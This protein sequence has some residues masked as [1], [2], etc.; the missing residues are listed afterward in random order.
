MGRRFAALAATA[1]LSMVVPGEAAAATYC[2]GTTGVAC[3]ETFAATGD[4]VQQALTAAGTNVNLDGS[5][6]TVR[7][8]PGSF[9]RTAGQGYTVTGAVIVAGEGPATVLAA[10]PSGGGS[11]ND[12]FRSSGSASTL[13]DL[14]VRVDGLAGA[15]VRGFTMVTGVRVTG[16]G[17]SFVGVALP[18]GGRGSRIL[19]DQGFARPFYFSVLLQSGAVL[20]DSVLRV[21]GAQTRGVVMADDPAAAQPAMVRHVTILGDSR[22]GT[23]GV[24]VVV[25]TGKVTPR[26]ATLVVR[27]SLIRG[28]N[29]ALVREGLAATAA[30]APCTTG[31]ANLD[32]RYSSFDA[33]PAARVDTGPG[34][35]TLGP[36]NLDDPDPLFVDA[37]GEDLRLLAGSPL[38]DAGDPSA[39]EAGDS[40]TD[41][42]GSPRIVG[43]RRDIGAY[44][45]G[46][47]LPSPQTPGTPVPGPAALAA[48]TPD[49][50]APVLRGA[51]LSRARF[52]VGRAGTALS[53]ARTPRAER[54]ARGTTVSYTLSE[55][56]TAVFTVEREL[57]GWRVRR[58]G[59]SAPV[60]LRP[61]NGSPAR[62]RRCTLRRRAGA[63]ARRAPAGPNTLRFSGRIGTRK[64]P[65]GSYRLTIVA[66]DAAGNASRPARLAFRIVS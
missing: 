50:T 29:T 1:V 62:G 59:R 31:T 24:S 30:C 13:R 21:R 64:L 17:E 42:G 32:V 53:A 38:I 45:G 7:I 20:E 34:S 12:A 48:G 33:A 56:A 63:L 37:P 57:A 54:P 3:D 66:K 10:S 25:P 65:A 55:A 14:V 8:G 23:A 16:L 52:R 18:M 44:E 5:P 40:P 26:A 22:A 15:G 47:V 11:V 35:L 28:V 39:P 46:V 9:T 41:A 6:N 58:T 4:G 43:A 61:T 51:K 36:G 27:D 60:C 2:V 19:V 49:V